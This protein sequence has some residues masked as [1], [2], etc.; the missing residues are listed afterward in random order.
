MRTHHPHSQNAPFVLLL[1]LAI[2]AATTSTATAQTAAVPIPAALAQRL[3][4]AGTPRQKAA[5]FLG[6][7]YRDDATVDE[8]ARFTLFEHPET[9]LEAPALNCSGFV[10]SVSRFLFNTN[11][12][13]S[14]AKKDRAGDSGPNSP[15]GRDWDFGLDLIRNITD[16]LPRRTILPDAS[17]PDLDSAT[18]HTLRGFPIADTAAWKNV[19]PRLRP[20]FAYLASISKPVRKTGY[21]LLHYHVALILPNPDGSVSFLHATPN[22]GAHQ[23]TISTP[24]GLAQLQSQ[25]RDKSP[26]EKHILIIEA[27]LP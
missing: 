7:P 12:T 1:A 21:T 9:T 3:K 26:A 6:I 23:L 4:D 24:K 19:L 10:L 11:I 15:H 22:S 20:G 8:F 13:L 16:G 5:A 27:P 17:S 2:L 14:Q 25:F 18:G